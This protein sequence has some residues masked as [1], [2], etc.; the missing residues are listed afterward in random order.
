MYCAGFLVATAATGIVNSTI[1]FNTGMINVVEY[2]DIA[3]EDIEK[4]LESHTLQSPFQDI[5]TK[6]DS[7][8]SQQK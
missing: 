7:Y 3:K 8:F 1:D 6:I 4:W 2:V 5:R